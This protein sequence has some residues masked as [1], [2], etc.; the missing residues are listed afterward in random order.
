MKEIIKVKQLSKS[1][2]ELI[3]VRNLNMSVKTG[4]VFG[5]LGANGA[6]GVMGLPLVVS[7]YRSKKILKRFKVTPVSPAIIVAVQV[8][9]YTIYSV[10]SLILLYVVSAFFLTFRC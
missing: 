2:G 8:V 5:M 4:T 7:H 9:I 6:G 1:Y 3:A 10:A